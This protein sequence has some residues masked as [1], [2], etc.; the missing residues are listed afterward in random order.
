MAISVTMPA[1]SPTMTE[2]KVAAWHKAVGDAVAPGDVLAEIE[3]D[4]AIMEIEAVDEGTL[5]KILVAEGT[6]EVPVN[7]V[8]AM[9]LEEGEGQDALDAAVEQAPQIPTPAPTAEPAATPTPTPAPPP[10]TV[11]APSVSPSMGRIVAS[12]L[13]RRMARDA[14]IDLSTLQGSGPGGR[15]IKRDVEGR[16]ATAPGS[17]PA[18]APIAEQGVVEIP[19]SGVRKIVAKRLTESWQTIPHIYL[20]IECELDALL[21]TRARLNQRA[22]GA[23][24]ISVNDF[25][26]RAAAFA[27][28]KV[29]AINVRWTDTAMH[30]LSSIDIAVAVAMEGGLITPIIREADQKGLAEISVEMKDLATRGR[31]GKLMP[32]EYQGGSFTISNLGMFGI[33]DFGAIINPPQVAIMAVGAGQKQ[34]VVRDGA[35]AIATVMA[36]TL[37]C[38]H[39]AVDGAVGAT[40]LKAFKGFIEEPL[41]MML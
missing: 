38:D 16:P 8:I 33:K 20:N 14:G 26:I 22:D 17:A 28:A 24:K 27:L 40:F 6:E 36:C 23:Y 1:L 12:P 3:T 19:H 7:S 35:V 2:G 9:I 4:K 25:I 21:E 29:P 37:S 13:A 32:E 15:I 10:V 39:R 41:T 34:P 5:G 18:T 11:A 30:Q 31:E